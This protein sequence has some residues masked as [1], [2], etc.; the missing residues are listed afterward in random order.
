MRSGKNPGWR[1]GGELLCVNSQN[2]ARVSRTLLIGVTETIDFHSRRTSWLAA[3]S[4][5]SRGIPPQPFPEVTGSHHD[6]ICLFPGIRAQNL[7]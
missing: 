2:R 5:T 7:D 3:R 4:T 1:F 6:R